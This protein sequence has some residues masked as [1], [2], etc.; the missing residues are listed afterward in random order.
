MRITAINAPGRSPLTPRL[1][2]RS[3]PRSPTRCTA[4]A[5]SP[6]ASVDPYDP[7]RAAGWHAPHHH[8]GRT[9]PKGMT[10]PD[11]LARVDRIVD[12]SG[13]S[14]GWIVET[15]VHH[16]SPPSGARMQTATPPPTWPPRS[17]ARWPT[18]RPSSGIHTAFPLWPSLT[19]AP[20]PGSS[21]QSPSP[22][23]SGTAP[24]PSPSGTP[25]RRRRRPPLRRTPPR[26]VAP[27]ERH[28][29]APPPHSLEQ[30]L[31]P[32]QLHVHRRIRHSLPRPGRRP[33]H[34]G[35]PGQPGLG[36][37]HHHRL[38]HRRRH[39]GPVPARRRPAPSRAAVA[40]P[41]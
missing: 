27:A 29:R 36:G 32:A 18:R 14:A 1:R 10:S 12:E 38:D 19:A 30:P 39:R 24:P 5:P 7:L 20:A 23:R 21:A 4:P 37:R 40:P 35:P 26:R 11:G 17:S 25:H 28:H 8:D 9:S 3:S 6:T 31:A 16:P 22:S 15:S 41:R 33:C 2:S 13:R 34:R